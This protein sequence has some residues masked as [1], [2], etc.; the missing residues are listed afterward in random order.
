MAVAQASSDSRPSLLR[1]GLRDLW[2]APSSQIPALDALRTAAIL[3]VIAGHFSE[4]GNAQFVRHAHF[5]DS[6]LFLFGWTGVDLFF[7]LS[8]FLIGGQLWK[9]LKRSGTINVGK[10]MATQSPQ[11]RTPDG[12][13]FLPILPACMDWPS[14]G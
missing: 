7:V 8:G 5:F 12:G 10:F 6:S 14:P 3:M 2:I 9:E 13:F 11:L 1:A 4:L